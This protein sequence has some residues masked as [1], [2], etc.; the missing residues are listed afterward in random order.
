LRQRKDIRIGISG[1]GSDHAGFQNFLGIAV[2]DLSFGGEDG[3]GVYHSIYD[4]F[5]WYT[6]YSDTDFAYGRALSQF[7]GSTVMRLADAD[8]LPFD[9]SDFADTVQTYVKGLQTFSSKMRDDIRE[10]NLEIE[11]G[12]FTASAD[13]KRPYFPPTKEEVPP[14]LNFSP[15]QNSADALTRSAG[16]YQTALNAA[17]ANR[18]SALTSASIREVNALLIESERKLTTPEGLPGRFWY[19]HQ[20]YAPGVYT[21]Y[22]SKAIPAVRE[23][24][25]QKKWKEAEQA[26]ARAAAV[27]QD[28]AV[29]VSSAAAKLS[30][31]S[32]GSR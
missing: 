17:E 31:A 22:E 30:A 14:H 4:D 13:P 20:I 25:E 18:G 19:K 3:G 7:N 23:A 9:F 29:L 6:H 32:A 1:G 16:E 12:V 28:E 26:M 5:Y 10:R 8:L 21:G 2:L 11:E 24:I 15:L 27:L